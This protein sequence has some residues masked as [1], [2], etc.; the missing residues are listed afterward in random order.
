MSTREFD[1]CTACAMVEGF[2]EEAADQEEYLAAWQYLIDTGIV[3]RLQG[4]YGRTAAAL[5]EAGH[6]YRPGP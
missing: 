4:W 2:G 5:I 3:W 6:C 1:S